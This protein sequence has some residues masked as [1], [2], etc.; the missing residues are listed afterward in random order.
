MA[1]ALDAVRAGEA[2]GAVVPFENSVE[3]SVTVTL[4]ELATGEPLMITREMTVPVRLALLARPGRDLDSVRTVATHPHA[5]AQSRGWLAR[6]LPDADRRDGRLDR[7]GG[8]RLV[9]GGG[10]SPPEYD[11]AIAAPIAAE[12]YRLAVLA[13][14]VGDNPRRRDPVRAGRAGRAARR[15]VRVRTRPRWSRSSATT[16]R[17]R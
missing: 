13:D 15:R 11:A 2:D 14:S 3:G 9:A 10:G 16:T 7:A 5:A 8:G 17:A 4:D 6:H 12:R 1:L